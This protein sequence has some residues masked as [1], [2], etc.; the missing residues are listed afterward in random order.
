M[1]QRLW[2]VVVA[3]GSGSRLG[4]QTPKQFLPLAGR[5]LLLYCLERFAGVVPARR[6]VLV[7]P[8]GRRRAWRACCRRRL[9]ACASSRAAP[10]ARPPWPRG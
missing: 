4:G 9:T 1:L 10:R 6:I 7:H 3:G 2:I 8:R 5:P